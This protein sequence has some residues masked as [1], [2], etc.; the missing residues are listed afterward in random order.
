M[1]S[2]LVFV[3]ALIQLAGIIGYAY[4]TLK[5]HTKPN[6]I[7]WML[8]AAAPLIGT[9]AA[10]SDGVSWAV[11]PVFMAGF[12]PL[13][14]LCVSFLNK[15][16]YWKL[17]WFDYICGLLAVLALVL[18]AITKE[19]LM[20]I[21]L[22]IAADGLAAL[23]TIVKSW[24]FPETESAIGY[25]ATIIAVSLGLSAIETWRLSEYLFPFYLIVI[26]IIILL[27]IYRKQIS[28][29]LTKNVIMK[30]G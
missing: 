10:V 17:T 19:P 24:Y 1:L 8:W 15:E 25:S 28:K 7:T 3:A 22:A 5:G 20:A 9:A 13:L 4:N 11:L 2:N 29:F 16:A 14:V 18:W 21:A 27:A 30:L 23:P 26:N 12:G 6:R